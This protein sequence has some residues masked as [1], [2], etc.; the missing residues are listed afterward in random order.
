MTAMKRKKKLSHPYP[1]PKIHSQPKLFSLAHCRL[2]SEDHGFL[3][4]QSVTG[5]D[6]GVSVVV[7]V[8]VIIGDARESENQKI[9]GH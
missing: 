7:I 4:L 1:N 3:P 8:V 2:S 5:L 6:I 9:V